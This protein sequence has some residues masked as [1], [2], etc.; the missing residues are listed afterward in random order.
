MSMF[1]T[2]IKIIKFATL[3]IDEYVLLG[4]R[5]M[6]IEVNLLSKLGFVDRI[7]C[8]AYKDMAL[9]DFYRSALAI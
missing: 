5:V 7:N 2:L 8:G 6:L 1:V 3:L 9:E 4:W